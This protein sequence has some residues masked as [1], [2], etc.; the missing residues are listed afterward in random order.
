MN[1]LFQQAS[2]E[3]RKKMGAYHWVHCGHL[4]FLT[5]QHGSKAR[6]L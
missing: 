2:N 6:E 5:Y 4:A 3:D 1:P